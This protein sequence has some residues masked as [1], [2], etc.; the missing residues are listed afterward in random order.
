MRKISLLLALMLMVSFT[1]TATMAGPG[2]EPDP[3]GGGNETTVP[4]S[5]HSH[6]V[7]PG[8]TLW[9][10]AL[11]YKVSLA[12]LLAAN[13]LTPASLLSV[14][15]MLVIPTAGDKATAG[16]ATKAVTRSLS[17]RYRVQRGNTLW[18]IA[19]AY[20]VT[21]EAVMKAN[22]LN[23]DSILAVGQ[24]LTIPAPKRTPA[25]GELAPA[26]LAPP[27]PIQATAPLTLTQVVSETA[28]AEAP[29]EISAT[30]GISEA[31]GAQVA[32]AIAADAAPPAEVIAPPPNELAVLVFTLINEK[33]AGHGLAPLAWSPLLA[34]A[35]QAH[36]EDCARRNYGSHVGADGARLRQRLA[37]AGYQASAASENW[38]FAR[39]PQGGVA[40]WYD[41]PP[42]ADAH[43]RNILS[44]QYSEV[45]VGVVQD[46]TGLYYIVA[47]FGRP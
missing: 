19:I 29:P 7:R 34:Q 17:V 18:D 45:G 33:R 13:R 10:I 4:P 27:A 14:G 38:V 44:S 36:A 31:V 28:A 16:V 9:D 24:E 39:S 11:A 41:E 32:A 43:R 47:D 2:A 1:A 21:I 25:A 40:W 26:P 30:D 20:G 8:D 23:K 6:T 15:Q 3:V 42:A 22:R 5:A 46:E 37:R 35:A 12:D